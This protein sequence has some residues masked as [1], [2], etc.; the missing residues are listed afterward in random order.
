MTIRN[1][2]VL[3][4]NGADR[5][6]ILAVPD[7]KQYR[8]AANQPC[9]TVGFCYENRDYK[10]FDTFTFFGPLYTA[11]C[12]EMEAARRSL[13]GSFRLYDMGADTDG[14]IDVDVDHG[15][16]TVKG[17]LGA[18]FSSHFLHFEFD[19]DQTFLTGLLQGIDLRSV[20]EVS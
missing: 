1:D 5:F 10:G 18:S 17:Q 19:A 8:Y 7:E 16:V 3:W 9:I 4:D 15:R 12:S 11:L 6:C 14:Y 13:D 20:R 2:T